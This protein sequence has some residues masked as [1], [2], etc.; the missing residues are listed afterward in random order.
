[1]EK[2]KK[3]AEYLE[4]KGRHVI[5]SYFKVEL[6]FGFYHVLFHAMFLISFDTDYIG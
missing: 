5:V 1:M 3:L 6:L 4:Q 2:R